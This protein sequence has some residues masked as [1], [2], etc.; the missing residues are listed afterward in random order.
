MYIY[1]HTCPYIYVYLYTHMYICMRRGVLTYSWAAEGAEEC[2][3]THSAEIVV[4][5][6]ILNARIRLS[7]IAF[8]VCVGNGS[9]HRSV[10][11]P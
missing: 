6:V 9:H 5:L 7:S 11:L 2:L 4:T 3:L 1:I 8:F 10:D